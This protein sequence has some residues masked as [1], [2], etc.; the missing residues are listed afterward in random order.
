MTAIHVE[1]ATGPI[2]ASTSSSSCSSRDEHPE[3][4]PVRKQRKSLLLRT[5]KKRGKLAPATALGGKSKNGSSTTASP[6][7][8][9]QEQKQQGQ[10]RLS[11]PGRSRA[12][13]LFRSHSVG[14]RNNNNNS[15]NNQTK[16]QQQQQKQPQHRTRP[17]ASAGAA[18]SR[19][20]RRTVRR[21]RSAEA[22]SPPPPS[23]SPYSNLKPDSSV[24]DL[25]DAMKQTRVFTV[26]RPAKKTKGASLVTS[27]VAT[28]KLSNKSQLEGEQQQV[29]AEGDLW[30]ENHGDDDDVSPH[31]ESCATAILQHSYLELCG[32]TRDVNTTCDCFREKTGKKQSNDSTNGSL[33]YNTR[34]QQQL[35]MPDDPTVQESIECVFASQLG[36][37]LALMLEQ[38][39]DEDDDETEESLTAPST[40]Q[41][42]LL[43]NRNERCVDQ[44]NAASK[45]Q[46]HRK[47]NKKLQ[48]SLKLV[49]VGTFDPND[50]M[51]RGTDVGDSS[52]IKA[53]PN[54]PARIAHSN[55]CIC[56]KQI[57]PIVDPKRWPQRPLLLRPS[58]NGGTVVKG[59]R[60]AGSTEYLWKAERNAT[61]SLTWPNILR[62]EWGQS[63][64]GTQN[65]SMD[66]MCSRCMILPI[67]NGNEAPGESLVADFESELFEGTLL[68]RMRA[69]HGTTSKPY[70]DDFGYFHGMNRRYQ[71]VVQGRFKKA[72]PITHCMTGFLLDRP[73]G[74]LPPKW[75]LKG[76]LKVLSFFAPQLQ[77]R[78]DGPHPSSLTPLGSTPQV[79]SV[80]DDNT[81][82]HGDI[83]QMQQEP[84]NDENTLLGEASDAAGTLQ[85]ARYRKKHFDKLFTQKS[86]VPVTDLSKVYTFEF[87]QHLFNFND[88]SIE[89][90][91]MLGSI[92]L[93]E[94]LDGQPLQ[95]MSLFEQQKIWSFDIWHECLV[96][97][98][99]VHDTSEQGGYC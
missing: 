94:I 66:L 84:T 44:R 1:E 43:R 79:L 31:A 88:F 56:C 83:E 51:L 34:S 72:I 50:S 19:Q 36:E 35:H 89:L 71:A 3:T 32:S 12:L 77:A 97:E 64:T 87:L 15:D 42:S 16:E 68:L 11:S 5:T 86:P 61:S 4:S 24:A 29:E 96:E 98:A 48:E 28:P 18:A 78:F 63:T 26:V 62:E 54:T 33:S 30:E 38:D 47:R 76:G 41:Q 23:S 7:V 40:F 39:D 10:Q 92:K 81:G 59:I 82:K 20:P 14:K 99:R 70:N 73:C 49:H 67:N 37:N 90:G 75:I 91:S 27:T 13:S 65:N 9:I 60:K 85:R 57:T 25:T 58:P 2:A 17:V 52:S 69:T 95:I 21:W 6:P 74:K 22:N 55:P 46:Q 80:H 93:K 45:Q 53:E 8:E